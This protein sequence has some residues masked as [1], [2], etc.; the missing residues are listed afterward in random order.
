MGVGIDHV[1]YA[2]IKAALDFIAQPG[3]RAG[4]RGIDDQGALARCQH[5]STVN[6]KSGAGRVPVKV[7]FELFETARIVRARGSSE[8]GQ[9]GVISVP[10]AV[11]RNA[12]V[13]GEGRNGPKWSADQ[14]QR[15][16]G[17]S[18]KFHGFLQRLAYRVNEFTVTTSCSEPF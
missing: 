4:H 17:T 8:V 9:H 10:G 2:H 12:V 7:A 16:C 1:A 18:G 5:K 11:D 6:G 3:R 14:T 13:R 15:D